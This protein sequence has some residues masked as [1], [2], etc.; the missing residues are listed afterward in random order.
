MR[1]SSWLRNFRQSAVALVIAGCVMSSYGA[2]L[3]RYGAPRLV[4]KFLF[5]R[6]YLRRLFKRFER[7]NVEAPTYRE[8]CRRIAHEL[9]D[10]SSRRAGRKFCLSEAGAPRSLISRFR[11]HV[12]DNELGRLFRRTHDLMNVGRALRIPEFIPV[13]PSFPLKC[14]VGLLAGCMSEREKVLV[15]ARMLST[16]GTFEGKSHVYDAL[17]YLL[18]GD[19]GGRGGLCRYWSEQHNFLL[20]EFRDFHSPKQLQ[21]LAAF[22][23]PLLRAGKWLGLN[24]PAQLLEG[25]RPLK[26]GIS[27]QAVLILA[28]EGVL[29]TGFEAVQPYVEED[30]FYSQD[31]SLQEAEFRE[32]VRILKC[33]GVS[34]DTLLGILRQTRDL[35]PS[36]LQATIELLAK[37]GVSDL[38]TLY[39]GLGEQLWTLTFDILRFLLADVGIRD[40]A[41]LSELGKLLRQRRAPALPV[42]NTIVKHAGHAGALI[43][44]Q[45]LLTDCTGNRAF[46]VHRL[47]LLLSEPHSLTLAQLNQC[48]Q[49]LTSDVDSDV[50]FLAFLEVLTRH[51]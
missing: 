11:E 17:V 43:E 1:G 10:R 20:A 35:D 6:F 31:E 13:L 8:F 2:T 40:A 27:A 19:S 51:G 39:A 30:R 3:N 36:K 26:R 29:A 23:L 15:A 12:Y 49:Y 25:L 28:E 48:T 21:A 46:P 24:N 34:P 9:Q 38:N 33:N 50:K 5:V 7:A 47:D 44:V 41:V 32:T 18:C 42:I 45:K 37:H 4:E 14:I 16:I 22:P